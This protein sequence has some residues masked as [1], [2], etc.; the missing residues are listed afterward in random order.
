M[1]TEKWGNGSCSYG[2]WQVRRAGPA[3]WRHG[4]E[5]LLQF[6]QGGCLLTVFL[7][8]WGRLVFVLLRSS[9][10]RTRPT[11]ILELRLLLLK[12]N[13][14]S[15]DLIPKRPHRSVQD[16]IWPNICALWPSQ[17]ETKLPITSYNLAVAILGIYLRELISTQNLLHDCL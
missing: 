16:N 15:D 12:A 14:F 1:C 10:D 5:P 11:H 13:W 2:V 4:A 7:L 17:V 3:G 6:K 8:H 9:P